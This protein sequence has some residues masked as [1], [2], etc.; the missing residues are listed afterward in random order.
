MA[1]AKT[2]TGYLCHLF[3]VAFTKKCNNQT[4]RNIQCSIPIRPLHCMKTVEILTKRHRQRMWKNQPIN[5]FQRARERHQ[6]DTP[7]IPFITEVKRLRKPNLNVGEPR[8]LHGKGCASRMATETEVGADISWTADRQKDSL[9]SYLRFDSWF[10]TFLFCW[11]RVLLCCSGWPGICNSPA[12]V[13]E[14]IGR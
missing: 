11:I 8:E 7:F 9:R 2:I 6:E 14:M 13:T 4:W 12:S 1:D 10:L 5:L 3:C